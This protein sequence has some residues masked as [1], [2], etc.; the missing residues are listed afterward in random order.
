MAILK[1]SKAKA[2]NISALK[3]VIN[4]VLQKSKTP[5][6]IEDVTGFFNSDITTEN[7]FNSFMKNK[8]T[9]GKTSGRLYTHSIVSFHKDEDI[10]PEEASE[11]AH[12]L[13]DKLYPGHQ[14][15]IVVHQD[16]KHTHAHLIVDSVSYETGK[17]IHT[18]KHDLEKQK[19][20]CNDL[21]RKH[22][23]SVAKKGK[24]F[25]EASVD[26]DSF[27]AWDKNT[28]RVIE[29]DYRKAKR[30]SDTYVN[31]VQLF[32]LLLQAI[33]YAKNLGD[34]F[35]Y[36]E[37]NAWKVT[38]NPNRK[39]IVFTPKNQTERRKVS[40]RAS[41]IEQVFK[42]AFNAIFGEDFSLDKEH[43]SKMMETPQSSREKKYKHSVDIVLG[44][45]KGW[46][47][48]PAKIKKGKSKDKATQKKVK[49]N[50]SKT[51]HTDDD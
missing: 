13:C 33:L 19:S 25:Y 9:W 11:F 43:L 1:V 29:K 30:P 4:Y 10:M 50:K 7:V 31:Y 15:L 38:W 44:N 27:I 40:Y 46:Q 39:N 16:K 3:G 22:G 14:A 34:F 17:K 23:Y 45:D 47:P 20:I 49:N 37:R 32:L 12:E 18:S 36:F 41:K 8:Q 26:Q 5:D 51:N 6:Q 21:C 42:P 35:N 2:T 24:N 48:D 28:Y